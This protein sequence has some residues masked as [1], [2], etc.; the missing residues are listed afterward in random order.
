MQVWNPIQSLRFEDFASTLIV[1]QDGTVLDFGCGRAYWLIKIAESFSVKSA[2]GV[3]ASPYAASA[4]KLRA[5][6]SRAGGR[7]SIAE[8]KCDPTAYD[9]E[10]IDLILCVGASH[11]LSNYET[12]LRESYRLLRPGGQL[13]IGEVYWKREPSPEYLAFLHCDR[14]TYTTSD[15]NCQRAAQVGY[16]L[17]WQHLATD[18]EWRTYEDQYARNVENYVAANTDDPDKDE[19]LFTVRSWHEHFIRFGRSTLG[20]GLYLFRKNSQ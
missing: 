19:M 17:E 7:I 20:F 9:N 10:S 15:A 14:G 11:A 13:L 4:A 18:L 2:I 5:A 8:G 16:T 12:A 6:N 3:D 1:P